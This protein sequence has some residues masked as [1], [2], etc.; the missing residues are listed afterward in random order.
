MKTCSKCKIQQCREEFAK[1]SHN[2][3]GLQYYCKTCTKNNK[4]KQKPQTIVEYR[5]NNLAK[6]LYISI[7][8]RA[9]KNSI[10][11]NL[12]ESDIKIPEFCPVLGIKLECNV[13]N[14]WGSGIKG[15]GRKDSSPSVDRINP[16]LGYTKG[17]IKV[18]SWRA[19]NLK[20]DGTM[21]EFVSIIK[22]LNEEIK[23]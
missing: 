21:E 1:S 4:Y 20:K 14:A 22:Y 9:K 8:A 19:N 17:N 2:A 10:D 16:E 18:I 11:F 13:G 6:I 12:D 5:R 7:K 3:D 15:F 23:K